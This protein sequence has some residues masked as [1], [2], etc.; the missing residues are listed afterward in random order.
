M[1]MDKDPATEHSLRRI[2]KLLSALLLQGLADAPQAD[3]AHALHLS[4]VSN[5]DIALLLGTTTAVVS[6]QLYSKR[7]SK[8]QR[9]AAKKKGSGRAKSAL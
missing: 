4:G 5:A 7:Q 9:P 6:Q 1:T 3:K 2:E 8:A